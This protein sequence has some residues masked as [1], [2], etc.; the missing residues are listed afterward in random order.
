VQLYICCGIYI[1]KGIHVEGF[2]LCFD[3]MLDQGKILD[4]SFRKVDLL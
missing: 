3:K 1:E 2:V 4:L